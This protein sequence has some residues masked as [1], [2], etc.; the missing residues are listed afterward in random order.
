M[1]NKPYTRRLLLSLSLATGTQ[2]VLADETTA[3]EI[4]VEVVADSIPANEAL[5]KTVLNKETIAQRGTGSATINDIAYSLP[6]VQFF[7][8]YN[9]I[10]EESIL[11][12]RPSRISISGGRYY[13]N[14][15]I[16]DGMSTNTL[17][18]ATNDNIH[19]TDDPVGHPQTV[20]VNPQMI[21]SVTVYDSNVP[22]AY[23]NFTGGVFEVET[24]DPSGEYHSGFNFGFES[25]D[26]M[27]YK[28]VVPEDFDAED[29]PVKAQF[30]KLQY[31]AYAEAPINSK[32]AALFEYSYQESKL[33]N[34]Q[35]HAS[36]S[37]LERSATSYVENYKARVKHTLN[38]EVSIKYT[39]IYT[40]SEMENY[41]QSLRTQ[42][43]TAWQHTAELLRQTDDSTL[44]ITTGY[45][46]SELGREHPPHNYNYSVTE[47]IDW[48]APGRSSASKG[49]WGNIDAT[50]EQLPLKADYT[51]SLTETAKI[52]IGAEYIY[53]H[54]TTTRAE[55]NYGYSRALVSDLVVSAEGP[56]DPTVIDG[57]QALQ[58]RNV[59]MAFD[60]NATVNSAAAWAEYSNEHQIAGTKLSYRFGL[61]Y[62]HEDFLDGD[63]LAP[64]L[65]ATWS[66]TQWLD[67][68]AGWNR[69]YAGNTLSFALK[70]NMP[71]LILERRTYTVN[72][73][74]QYVY[75]D[76]GWYTYMVISSTR[77]SQADVTTPYNDEF[78]LATTFKGVWGNFKLQYTDRD[79]HDEF[80]RTAIVW[81]DGDIDNR[82]WYISN[83]GF[84]NYEAVS[85]DWTKEWKNHVF[86]INGTFSETRRSNPTYYDE[87]ENEDI[88][89]DVY[90]HE[91]IITRNELR[92]IREGFGSPD[93]V[94]INWTSF[95]LKDDRLSVTL[96]GRIEL[97]YDSIRQNGS[98]KVAGTRYELYEDYRVSDRYT[99][100]LNTTW[101]AYDSPEYGRLSLHLKLRNIFNDTNDSG[102]IYEYAYYEEGR[103]AWLGF[104]YDF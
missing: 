60:A 2:Y 9:E 65:V 69:Y 51:L 73:A 24:K 34:Q 95:W 81:V 49:G 13:D 44:K 25:D 94:N 14:N 28:L 8:T 88:L 17:H 89:E 16:V 29:T 46:S 27:T 72:D 10:S 1:L 38:D 74:G 85:F 80:A 97:A 35:P 90:Y 67:I 77:Y 40:P 41:E 101:V 43:N 57:E 76:D 47:S 66:P 82:K 23:G 54:A 3:P 52:N 48:V 102:D 92:Q 61:R 21:E 7:N 6:N 50:E 99:F 31:G 26:T 87:Y 56:D 75:S 58:Q 59:N 22:A 70:E 86:N 36:Y 4:K 91:A 19:D 30:T 93:F 79:G 64:R 37:Y 42:E 83:D 11:D 84:S 33:D 55:T 12:V 68:T 63:N 5:G 20:F 53:Q 39:A 96:N 62:D 104:S 78:T 15:F 71:D 18:D 100:N 32:T 98:I 45:Q 103:S